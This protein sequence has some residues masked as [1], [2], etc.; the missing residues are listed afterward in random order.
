MHWRVTAVPVC[1]AMSSLQELG[2][3]FSLSLK[4]RTA[5][6]KICE[7]DI[8]VGKA[9]C[10]SD[11]CAPHGGITQTRLNTVAICH[12]HQNLLDRVDGKKL[13]DIFV[14]RNETRLSIFGNEYTSCSSM[15]MAEFGFTTN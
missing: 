8:G 4:C 5:F 9:D 3:L 15:A 2:N 11:L 7:S 14:S 13:T 1:D 12:V 6:A 10:R